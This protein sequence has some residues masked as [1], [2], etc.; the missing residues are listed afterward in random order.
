M[1]FEFCFGWFCCFVFIWL[2]LNKIDKSGKFIALFLNGNEH[3]FVH[4]P[5]RTEIDG[6][7]Q[8]LTMLVKENMELLQML[9][10]I[11]PIGNDLDVI[12]DIEEIEKEVAPSNGRKNARRVNEVKKSSHKPVS[13]TKLHKEGYLYLQ[14][15]NSKTWTKYYIVLTTSQ[16]SMYNELNEP[17]LAFIKVDILHIYLF[18]KQYFSC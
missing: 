9:R 5:S 12:E 3:C 7:I 14:T 15:S 17:R 18:W 8:Q 2:L 4:D 11:K 13:V 1:I 16:I 6:Q 10:E